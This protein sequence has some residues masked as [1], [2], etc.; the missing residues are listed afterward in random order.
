MP[1]LLAA[2][3]THNSDKPIKFSC[4]WAKPQTNHYDLV[5]GQQSQPLKRICGHR[6]R[7]KVTPF[8]DLKLKFARFIIYTCYCFTGISLLY[9]IP[10]TG[11]MTSS[12]GKH[13]PRCWPFV[14]GIHRWP[15]NAD[16]ISMSRCRH[17]QALWLSE[18]NQRI[19]QNAIFFSAKTPHGSVSGY[20][21]GLWAH[22]LVYLS[23][24][25]CPRV[26]DPH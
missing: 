11:M 9:I 24:Q 14:R 21:T 8:Y 2:C 19:I 12:N 3:S 10:I 1:Y 20:F 7:K 18:H 4:Y 16:S 22:G 13:F 5:P 23:N 15:S 26:S 6:H 17:D 25:T